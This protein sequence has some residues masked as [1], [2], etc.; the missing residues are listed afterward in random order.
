M[1]STLYGPTLTNRYTKVE[2]V[3]KYYRIPYFTVGEASPNLLLMLDEHYETSDW[4]RRFERIERP[5]TLED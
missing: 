1:G 4:F 5:I 3:S 2:T